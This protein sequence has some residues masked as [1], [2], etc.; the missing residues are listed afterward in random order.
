MR[1]A[2]QFFAR[3]STMPSHKF[4]VGESVTLRPAISRNMPG[5]VYEVTKQLPHNGLEFEYRIKSANEEHERVAR[6]SELTK[7]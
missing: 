4:H 1:Q 7:A 2:V 6:E 5:G 3:K